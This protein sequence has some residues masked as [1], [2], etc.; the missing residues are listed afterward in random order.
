[1][2]DGALHDGARDQVFASLDAPGDILDPLALSVAPPVASPA[3]W[4]QVPSNPPPEHQRRT[5]TSLLDLLVT[6]L[7]IGVV[8]LMLPMSWLSRRS[9]RERVPPRAGR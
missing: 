2:H 6:P 7:T 9:R 1:M 4:P 3:D 5:G 8:A